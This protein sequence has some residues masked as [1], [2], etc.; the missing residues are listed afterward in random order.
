VSGAITVEQGTESE[1]EAAVIRAIEVLGKDG[2]FI[3][4]P[5]DNLREDTPNA[6][7]N[8]AKLI[9]VWQKHRGSF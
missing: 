2:G 6:W 5:V 4:S 1:T 8:T 9:K 3:L 7:R